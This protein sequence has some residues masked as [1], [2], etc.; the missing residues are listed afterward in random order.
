MDGQ[1]V[2]GIVNIGGAIG[3][4][5]KWRSGDE[6]DVV[7]TGDGDLRGLF[8]GGAAVEVRD[9][10]GVFLA[11]VEIEGGGSVAR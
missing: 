10:K 7:G 4:D 9:L 3:I 2:I 11:I 8:R 1:R 6:D 5:V